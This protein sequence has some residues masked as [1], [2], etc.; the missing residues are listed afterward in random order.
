SGAH[1]HRAARA[2]ARL[3]PAR[4]D[5]RAARPQ[6]P[7]PHRLRHA[8]PAAGRVHALGGEPRDLARP[9]PLRPRAR[10]PE[11]ARL[12]ARVLGVLRLPRL[13]AAG[14]S[15]LAPAADCR[16]PGRA[17]GGDVRGGD[18]PLRRADLHLHAALSVLPRRLRDLGA[19]RPAA[20]RDRDDGR[21]APHAR[22]VR[23]AAPAAA[24]EPVPQ[25]S[26]RRSD[27]SATSFSFEPLFLALAVVAAALYWRAARADRPATWRVVA[28]A[29]GLFL[30]AAS[31][32]SPL[33]TVASKYLLLIHLLQNGLIA[34]LAPLLVLLGL[35]PQMREAIGRRGLN[36]L[37]TRWILPLWLGAWYLTHLAP[38]YDWALRT[39]W[40]LNIEH[41][42]LIAAGLLFWWPIVSG[43]LS[44]PA[45]LAYLVIA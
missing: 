28:F 7:R 43:R 32:N 25:V 39:G 20:G 8:P 23:R 38:F 3:L 36:R 19:P 22:G 40:G 24:L 15:R 21:A 12:R 9:L 6:C 27:V 16:R 13:D 14:R 31:L 11:P 35:T 45:G 2:A 5:P 29:S 37:R 34:D 33:E 4:A 17:R 41:A 44:P 1:G 42:I 30:I 10:A 18:D 26:P